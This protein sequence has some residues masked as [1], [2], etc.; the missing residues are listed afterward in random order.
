LNGI[1]VYMTRLGFVFSIGLLLLTLV[2]CFRSLPTNTG[3]SDKAV[4]EQVGQLFNQD[5]AYIQFLDGRFGTTEENAA[6]P[7]IFDENDNLIGRDQF[8]EARS[9][10]EELK[11]LYTDIVTF[12]SAMS[13][14]KQRDQTR[15][16]A[17]NLEEDDRLFA[18]PYNPARPLMVVDI[19]RTESISAVQ[20]ENIVTQVSGPV[21]VGD[22]VVRKQD[23][24]NFF[25]PGHVGIV[26]ALNDASKLDRTDWNRVSGGSK[27]ARGTLTLEAVGCLPR[28]SD[29]QLDLS[30]CHFAGDLSKRNIADEIQTRSILNAFSTDRTYILRVK[31]GLNDDQKRR[32]QELAQGYDSG[33]I[34]Y[35]LLNPF[36]RSGVY[37]SPL[38]LSLL[39]DVGAI[40]SDVID[41][42]KIT[43]FGYILPN[44]V[45]D[46]LK[47]FLNEVD[48]EGI[49]T[50]DEDSQVIDF[51]G[52][53]TSY[54]IE[55]ANSGLVW[56]VAGNSL[57]DGSRLIQY[58]K[59]EGQNQQFMFWPTVE[60]NV[61]EIISSL[62]GKC[63]DI[64]GGIGEPVA[65]QFYRCNYTDGQK[66]RLIPLRD[67][68]YQIRRIGD[69]K[70]VNVWGDSK[71]VGGVLGTYRCQY[72]TPSNERFFL[73][74]IATDQP[75]PPPTIPGPP[76]PPPPTPE[77]PS[78][79]T[80]PGGDLA[81]A[82]LNGPSGTINTDTPTLSWQSVSGAGSYGLYVLD[83]RSGAL[84][85]QI[86]YLNATSYTVPSGTLQNGVTY[87][88]NTMSYRPDGGWSNSSFSQSLSFTVQV[89]A[90]PPPPAILPPP[91][92]IGP[93]GTIT[94]LTPVLSWQPVSGAGSYGVYVRDT[95]SGELVINQDYWSGT[96]YPIPAGILKNGVTYR[97]NALSFRSDGTYSNSSFAAAMIFNVQLPVEP[98]P[99]PTF[100]ASL[101]PNSQS[102]VQGQNVQTKLS[103]VP[104]NGFSGV[105]NIALENPPSGVTVSPSS[106]N[107]NGATKVDLVINT[108][109]S[110]PLNNNSL[111]LLLSASGTSIGVLDNLYVTAPP[112]P[113][114]AI[115]LSPDSLSVARGSSVSSVLTINPYNGFSG[116]VQ[117]SLQNAPS[118]VTIS[119]NSVNVN[120]AIPFDVNINW[121]TSSATP[122]ATHDMQIV[123]NGA[124][125][126][127][128]D[129]VSLRVNN[130]NIISVTISPPGPI[131]LY[132]SYE[133]DFTA[134]VSGSSNTAVTWT[135]TGGYVSSGNNTATYEANAGPGTYLLTA[136]SVADPSKSATVSIIVE[137]YPIATTY[138]VM[139]ANWDSVITQWDKYLGCNG[140]T[141]NYCTDNDHVFGA[142]TGRFG[143]R[144]N[145][146]NSTISR[147]YL[148]AT[149]SSEYESIS[150]ANQP[151]SVS[152]IVNGYRYP[153][154]TVIPD[155]GVG[156]DYTW[157]LN[158]SHLQASGT[159][160]II[161][162]V[163]TTST[164]KNG[165]IIYYRRGSSPIKLD[166]YP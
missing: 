120:S 14:L 15:I 125:I 134:F 160:T 72:F 163:E 36:D 162:A 84:V 86:E 115:A 2:S 127:K 150:S 13:T 46:N 37:C 109:S 59:H 96:S 78:P 118:G 53:L 102:V 56:D 89:T 111:N 116:T 25:D 52:S 110:T 136:T 5:G 55:N 121:N 141:P 75:I 67:G 106:V 17:L 85:V 30:N 131:T 81:P 42:I 66:W 93:S 101:E 43:S 128:S 152:L 148:T 133:Q 21:E 142:S 33:N 26:V 61:Y 83:T 95:V 60:T 6:V 31:N 80:P 147:A 151:S 27:T 92:L 90:P 119:P 158:P 9:N 32:I 48:N 57:S 40:S 117:L 149:L 122:I 132:P 146:N 161:F 123:A 156:S 16:D 79:V 126:I 63:L 99:T 145:V 12:R 35:E 97:W 129:S 140:Y 159:N 107:V 137:D 114:F 38:A 54:V 24:N 100:T 58:T 18:V 22:I 98:P 94:T 82:V 44:S 65:L 4:F 139:P 105:V 165:L 74:P 29:D 41:I 135:A 64:P 71:D 10:G 144:V 130:P 113:D 49:S 69:R 166:V 62:S 87:N 77:P 7:V 124:G 45:V 88:W 154:I 3:Q 91:T 76:S 70:C 28:G 108:S 1:G 112:A 11:A 34:K 50:P 8:Q 138:E 157:T 47:A 73:R 153:A 68:S 103:I 39:T 51:S 20:S 19:Y 143:Y 104:Q 164:Y 23:P 155:D